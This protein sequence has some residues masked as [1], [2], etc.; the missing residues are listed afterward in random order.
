MEEE[1]KRNR[2]GTEQTWGSRKY[3]SM[4]APQRCRINPCHATYN[5][6]RKHADIRHSQRKARATVG[7]Q[8]WLIPPRLE[9]DGN[10]TMS[11]A[12]ERG[13]RPPPAPARRLPTVRPT[14]PVIIPAPDYTLSRVRARALGVPPGAR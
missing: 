2:R 9:Q 10:S 5:E 1:Q 11:V 8:P 14:S 13:H 3:V 12:I 7:P 6:R 4:L